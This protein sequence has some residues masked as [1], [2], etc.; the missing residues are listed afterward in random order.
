[1]QDRAGWS[2]QAGPLRLDC[3]VQWLHVAKRLPS[4]ALQR[5]LP[6]VLEHVAACC[7]KLV[8]RI[9]ATGC[10]EGAAMLR[11]ACE[12]R[13]TPSVIG[14]ER[15]MRGRRPQSLADSR[16]HCVCD[17]S[18]VR[19]SRGCRLGRK[20]RALVRVW[21]ADVWDGQEGHCVIQA[22]AGGQAVCEGQRAWRDGTEGE[23]QED[24]C[25]GPESQECV[26]GC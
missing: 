25:L 12:P 5:L 19:G 22:K 13:V 20:L 11:P 21:T 16:G 7:V 8:D 4:L 9:L 2:S 24:P 17:A 3:S 15:A 6:R 26:W 23:V 10:T 18:G 14:A 1:M